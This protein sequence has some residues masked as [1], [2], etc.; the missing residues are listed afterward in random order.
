MLKAQHGYSYNPVD[1][2]TIAGWPAHY[3]VIADAGADPY[4]LDLSAIADGD[5]PV[6]TAE[7]GRG[8]VEF[9]RHADSFVDFLKEV[10]QG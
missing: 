1:Q 7:H 8:R 9:A 4:C 10:A 5:A 3:V 6:Y 2:E